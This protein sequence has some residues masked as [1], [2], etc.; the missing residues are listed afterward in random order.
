MKALHICSWLIF[1][2]W[3]YWALFWCWRYNSRLVGLRQAPRTNLL[4]R[5]RGDFHK[6][7]PCNTLLTNMTENIS[8]MEL[9]R[10]GA[11]ARSRLASTSTPRSTWRTSCWSTGGTTSPSRTPSP[12]RCNSRS[13]L[14][15]C[16][17]PP[18]SVTI[19]NY[20]GS[21]DHILYQ[22]QPSQRKRLTNLGESSEVLGKSEWTGRRGGCSAT[23][24]FDYAPPAAN[25]ISE[26]P[27][28]SISCFV[29]F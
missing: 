18:W 17:L 12:S 4:C 24:I 28:F 1:R 16:L 21:S 20:W 5:K 3:T 14:D 23:R 11:T 6:L 7:M 9:C 19:T 8:H 29:C 10:A 22:L 25:C 15:R 27:I 26:F 13:S 2:I